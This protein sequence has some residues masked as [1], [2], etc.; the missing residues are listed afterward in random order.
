[1][2]RKPKSKEPSSVA[3][4]YTLVNAKLDPS[5]I[6]QLDQFCVIL[7][8]R[9]GLKV[10]RSAAIRWAVKRQASWLLNISNNQIDLVNDIL[11]DKRKI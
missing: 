8:E 3:E 2:P 10:T 1:M 7:S 6:A 5:E 11:T 4:K 9:L